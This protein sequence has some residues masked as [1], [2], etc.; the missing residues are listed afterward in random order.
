MNRYSHRCLS[1]TLVTVAMIAAIV[2]AVPAQAKT[3]TWA[4]CG[5]S[6]KAFMKE[7]AAAFEKKTGVKIKLF[8]GGATKGIRQVAARKI[9]LGGSCR[10]TIEN[11]RNFSSHPLERRVSM[12]PVAWD[13]LVVIVHK[14]N[15]INNITREQIRKIYTGKIKNWKQLGGKNAPIELYVRKGKFSGVGRTIRELI[16]AN[17]DQEFVGTHVVKS[18]GPLERAIQGDAVNGIGITGISSARKRVGKIKIL[19]LEGKEPSYENIKSGAYLLYRPLYLVTHLQNEDPDV[20]R[21][22]TFA[23]SEEAAEILRKVGTVPY[24]DGIQLWTKYLG[25]IQTALDRGLGR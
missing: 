6:K 19:K 24:T 20:R 10:A 4:G 13:A 25:Q 15:P 9:D 22:V 8:G 7:L 21:F 16:F 23:Q 2:L 17:Y 11:P 14:T 5:I 12:L 3:L 18:S 1:N